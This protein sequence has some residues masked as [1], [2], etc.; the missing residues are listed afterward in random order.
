MREDVQ[1][2]MLASAML[3]DGKT[4]PEI[5][6]RARYARA[7][8]L[9]AARSASNYRMFDQF[10]PWFAA[11]AI[12]QLQLDAARASIRKSGVEMYF[13][14][15][16]RTDGKSVAGLETVHDQIALFESMSHGRA[17]AST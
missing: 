11:E 14:E 6:G 2:E 13:L 12:S 10:A 15:R 5:M 1:S 7:Q 9:G 8:R 17:G 16:A 3:P 4:L